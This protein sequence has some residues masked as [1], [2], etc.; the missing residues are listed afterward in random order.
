[1]FT[2]HLKLMMIWPHF[3]MAGTAPCFKIPDSA[4]WQSLYLIENS[5]LSRRAIGKYIEVG[6]NRMDIKN[7]ASTVMFF[8]T[9]LWSAPGN[10]PGRYRR[11]QAPRRTLEFIKLVQDKRD[12]NRSQ[13]SLPVMVLRGGAESQQRKNPTLTK[14]W[15]YVRSV[16]DIAVTFWEIFSKRK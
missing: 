3:H 7:S 16:E 15:R 2:G 11:Q 14:R 12:N 1:M 10:R 4:V 13:A 6:I 5:E 9:H 8:P